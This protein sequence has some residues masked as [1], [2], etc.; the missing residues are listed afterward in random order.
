MGEAHK[1][2]QTLGSQAKSVEWLTLS[3]PHWNTALARNVLV[4]ILCP[5]SSLSLSISLSACA[6]LGFSSSF[7]LI[8]DFGH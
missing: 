2:G 7:L 5:I 3:F 1:A 4:L 8:A 6:D